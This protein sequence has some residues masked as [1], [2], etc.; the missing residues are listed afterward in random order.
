M[1]SELEIESTTLANTC[2]SFITDDK[3]ISVSGVY[4]NQSGVLASV[5]GA[6]GI[7]PSQA[8]DELLVREALQARDW[9]ETITGETF[10]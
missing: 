8:P 4:H 1:F 5:S 2:Y 9:F 10:L 3:A 7:S 6:G